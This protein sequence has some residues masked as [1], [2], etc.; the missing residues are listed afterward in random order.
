MESRPRNSRRKRQLTLEEGVQQ[1]TPLPMVRPFKRQSMVGP[2]INIYDDALHSS[3]CTQYYSS[4][5]AAAAAVAEPVNI[6]NANNVEGEQYA[7]QW[8]HD[9]FLTPSYSGAPARPGPA[10]PGSA[11]SSSSFFLTS[12]IVG[13]DQPTFCVM[14]A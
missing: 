9:N 5:D 6:T 10:R 2:I 3:S 8:N 11:L 13:A 7:T 1:D 14:L 12:L 4:P